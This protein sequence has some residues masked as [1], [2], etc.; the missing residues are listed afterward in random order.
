MFAII[1]SNHYVAGVMKRGLAMS[2]ETITIVLANR[3]RI[4]RELLLHALTTAEGNFEVVEVSEDHQLPAVLE[5]V[6]PDWAIIGA[7]PNE[8]TVPATLASANPG[9]AIMAVATDGSQ[10]SIVTHNGRGP[11]R[12]EYPDISLAQLM[13]LLHRGPQ[14]LN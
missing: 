14:N 10:V 9:L 3:P 6:S 4:L 2:T 7:I 8:E 1:E 11:V 12:A 13:T 5:R